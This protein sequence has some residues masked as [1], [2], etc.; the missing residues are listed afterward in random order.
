MQVTSCEAQATAAAETRD[1]RTMATLTSRAKA[2]TARSR[3]RGY[4]AETNAT[5]RVKQIRT[6][7][8]EKGKRKSVLQQADSTANPNDINPDG[9]QPIPR[10]EG[11]A[12]FPP[13]RPL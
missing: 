10:V 2:L 12:H 13:T 4:A 1:P 3:L 8:R 11:S 5:G 9:F 6:K 7:V